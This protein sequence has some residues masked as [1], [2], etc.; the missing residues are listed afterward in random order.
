[1][2]RLEFSEEVNTIHLEFSGI[3]AGLGG[4]LVNT[5]KIIAIKYNEEMATDK[6]DWAK[7]VE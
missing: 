4:I 7:A 6:E 5:H 1:M 3:G 2:T